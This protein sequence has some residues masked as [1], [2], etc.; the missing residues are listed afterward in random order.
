VLV[1][2]VGVDSVAD[3]SSSSL[4]LSRSMRSASAVAAFDV[5]KSTRGGSTERFVRTDEQTK[6]KRVYQNATQK[7][8]RNMCE[9]NVLRMRLTPSA[10]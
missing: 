8:K 10:R 6:S 3:R 5:S 7:Q 1:V 2:V 4:S 9:L